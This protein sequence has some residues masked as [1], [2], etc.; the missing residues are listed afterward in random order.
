MIHRT[1]LP[2]LFIPMLFTFCLFGRVSSAQEP[3]TSHVIQSRMDVLGSQSSLKL[4]E[5]DIRAKLALPMFYEGRGYEPVWTDPEKLAVLRKMIAASA[6]DG[7][8]PEDY[9][10][11][12]INVLTESQDD[13]SSPENRANLD[14]LCTDA[15]LSLVYELKFGK[16]DP[17]RLDADWNIY[18][19]MVELS[20]VIEQME[21]VF[22][23]GAADIA[24]VIDEI[25]PP[26]RI[27]RALSRAL[28][29]YRALEKEGGW[30]TIPDGE[31]LKAGIRDRRVVELRERLVV[32]GD[33]ETKK[34]HDD[35]FDEELAQGVER[36]QQR[37]GLDMDGVVG[38]MT[39]AA[40]N[41]PVSE[42]TDRIRVNLER[43][44]W[45]LQDDSS[46]FI[47]VNIAAFEVFYIRN[48]EFVWRSRVQ[49][50]KEYRK[51]PVFRA[52]MNYI[53]FNPTWTVP[54][55]IL[56]KDI[57]PKAAKDPAYLD[58]RNIKVIDSQGSIIPAAQ[59]D[60]QKYLDGGFPYTLRQ[61]PGP[62]NALGR[63]K[64]IFPN[65]HY[66]FLH[67]TSHRSYF[68][69]SKRSFSS[70]CIRVENPLEFAEILL[71]DPGNWSI[72]KIEELIESAKTRTVHLAE[73]LPVFLLYWTAFVD[74]DGTV[75]FRE[76]IYGRDGPILDDLGGGFQARNRHIQQR[77]R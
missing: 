10:L 57:I 62:N 49:V 6:D 69:R 17:E 19:D 32:T 30:P 7:L 41:I 74:D 77:G 72:D 33:L 27:Y 22:E 15:L 46:S 51:T 11:G 61:D 3:P 34:P 23:G 43:L 52:D 44:R 66:V 25:R 68:S 14:I 54:P 53:V 70:G 4:A 31:V 60:W 35:L 8:V 40:L 71:N 59:V 13:L 65:K 47:V 24:R 20:Q 26:Y 64:F 12:A 5:E 36:F 42:K 76:D 29:A 9:H 21:E 58:A 37:H 73:P 75:N 38:K 2:R 63:V 28:V 55:T 56:K 16:V 48:E 50:G 45:V 67:D 39:L 18:E 1:V